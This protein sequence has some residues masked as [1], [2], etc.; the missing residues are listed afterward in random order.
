MG[1]GALEST[2]LVR[3]DSELG[4]PEERSQ[5][6]DHRS[7][8]VGD[9][10]LRVF[11]LGHREKLRVSG[12]IGND[13]E[14]ILWLQEHC[15]LRRSGTGAL[16]PPSK[17][18]ETEPAAPIDYRRRGATGTRLV[19]PEE[20]AGKGRAS[21]KVYTAGLMGGR[22]STQIVINANHRRDICACRTSAG[23]GGEEEA[24]ALLLTEAA[25]Q[26]RLGML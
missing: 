7:H 13:E 17:R 25:W 1:S 5:T 11:E 10:V 20:S 21:R 6:L 18:Q 14:G 12:D 2:G 23:L 4:E 8:E 3:N 19:I 15:I 22:L 24:L 9:D 16:H 26:V